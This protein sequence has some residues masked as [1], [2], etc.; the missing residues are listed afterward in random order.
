M[1]LGMLKKRKGLNSIGQIVMQGQKW[2]W[3][4]TMFWGG[5]ER[6]IGVTPAATY[7][8]AYVTMRR[9]KAKHDISVVER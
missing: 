5:R 1:Q 2:V 4:Q 9:S 7:Q 3:G 6:P 8:T